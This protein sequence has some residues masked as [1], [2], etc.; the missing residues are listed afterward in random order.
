MGQVD[1]TRVQDGRPG[2]TPVGRR[3]HKTMTI[4]LLTNCPIGVAGT[5]RVVIVDDSSLDLLLNGVAEIVATHKDH[6]ERRSQR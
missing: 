3:A 2:K 6:V 1:G 5:T 4:R